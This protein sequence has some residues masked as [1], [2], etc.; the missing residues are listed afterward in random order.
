[1]TAAE[2]FQAAYQRVAGTKDIIAFTDPTTGV[3]TYPAAVVVPLEDDADQND[4]MDGLFQQTV[5]E[6][7]A[8]IVEFD[9]T[10][11]RRGQ[12]GVDDL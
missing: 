3:L 10:A 5:T 11:D 12:A 7:I 8:V 1:M 4:T 6:K 9:A 2:G